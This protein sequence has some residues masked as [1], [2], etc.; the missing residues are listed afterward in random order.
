[1]VFRQRGVET[2]Y[3]FLEVVRRLHILIERFN[4]LGKEFDG[5]P[6]PIQKVAVL[7]RIVQEKSRYHIY[8]QKLTRA[9]LNTIERSIAEVSKTI[10]SKPELAQSLEPIKKQFELILNSIIKDESGSR[11]KSNFFRKVA[12]D[13]RGQTESSF[14]SV[15]NNIKKQLTQIKKQKTQKPKL[16]PKF[17]Q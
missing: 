11:L 13:L 15:M 1:M 5:T 9:L 17:A 14:K 7:G 3:S 10:S 12:K 16:I 8:D 6:N 2:Q 4:S